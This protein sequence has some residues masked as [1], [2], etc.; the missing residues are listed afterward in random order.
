VNINV[1]GVFPLDGDGHEACHAA[2]ARWVAAES[3]TMHT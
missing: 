3:G 2:V 1:R